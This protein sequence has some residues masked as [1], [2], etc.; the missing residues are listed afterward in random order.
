MRTILKCYEGSRLYGTNSEKSDV[1]IAGI[2]MPSIEEIVSLKEDRISCLKQGNQDVQ[3]FPL[4]KFLNLL[5]QGNSRCV[6]M[7]FIPQESNF[8]AAFTDEYDFLKSKKDLFLNRHLIHKFT[9]FA[10]SEFMKLKKDTGKAGAKR[11]EVMHE[12]GF[13]VKSAYHCIRLLLECKEL[14]ETKR[15]IFPLMWRE[16]LK[17]IKEGKSSYASVCA[18][19]KDLLDDVES[20]EKAS[21]LP[22]HSEFGK[23]DNVYRDLMFGRL[24]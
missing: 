22:G 19:Y 15:L 8:N 12:F 9:G 10:K 13:N 24:K 6:E 1:D 16:D 14:I 18:W 4:D 7:L 3:L 21:D 2:F 23:C 20:L 17:V 11:K 5:V